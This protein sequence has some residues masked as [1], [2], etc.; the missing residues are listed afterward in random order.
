MDQSIESG[1]LDALNKRL[2]IDQSV[3]IKWSKQSEKQLEAELE[4]IS[5]SYYTIAGSCPTN[6]LPA[7][8]Q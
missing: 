6:Y 1:K 8:L 2:L 7:H 5:S 3:S 4:V